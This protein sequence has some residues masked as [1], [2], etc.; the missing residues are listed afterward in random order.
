MAHLV[1]SSQ[2]LTFLTSMSEKG[3]SASPSAIQVKKRQKTVGIEE[4][5]DVIMQREKGERII[6]ICHN[7]RLADG[8]VHKV[9]DN[10][11]RIKGS[12]KS[13]TKVF[14]CLAGLPQSYPNEPYRKLWMRVFYIFITLDINKYIV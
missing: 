5:L 9:H 13:G 3:K 11:D 6:D 14:V 4:K 10:G 7:V 1:F 12:A 8:F 2:A